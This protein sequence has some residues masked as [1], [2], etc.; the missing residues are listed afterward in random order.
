MFKNASETITFVSETSKTQYF[1]LLSGCWWAS[2]MNVL[3]QPSPSSTPKIKKSQCFL[4]F[5]N[6]NVQKHNVFF[7]FQRSRNRPTA[8]NMPTH[9]QAWRLS[10]W[11]V[12]LDGFGRLFFVCVS[13]RRCD[14]KNGAPGLSA[15]TQAKTALQNVREW[16]GT[17]FC[18]AGADTEFKSLDR[19][20]V[21]IDAQ[22]Q[23]CSGPV[24][25]RLFK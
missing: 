22:N 14:E 20:A 13:L 15:A 19:A 11:L 4:M 9:Q 7:N 5:S 12:G 8:A 3:N 6:A 21:Q 2:K 10:C 24:W 16:D 17:D 23:I 1:W 25:T 18:S